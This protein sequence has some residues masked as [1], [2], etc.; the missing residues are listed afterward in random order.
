MTLASEKKQFPT[1]IQTFA[2][3]RAKD[4]YYVDKTEYTCVDIYGVKGRL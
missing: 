1:G 4:Y 2:K 3:I